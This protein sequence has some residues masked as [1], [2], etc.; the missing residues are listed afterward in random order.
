MKVV[1]TTAAST[2]CN[3]TGKRIKPRGKEIPRIR[4]C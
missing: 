4:Q 2:M 3:I 1:K